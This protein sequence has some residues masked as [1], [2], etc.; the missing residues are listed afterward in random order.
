MCSALLQHPHI[1]WDTVDKNRWNMFHIAAHDN[2][3][4]LMEYLCNHI[5]KSVQI[6]STKSI[7]YPFT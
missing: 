4:E 2:H 7:S 5:K 3:Y 1:R 6:F